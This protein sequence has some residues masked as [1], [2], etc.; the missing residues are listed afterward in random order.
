MQHPS[1]IQI[2]CIASYIEACGELE[3][4]PFFGKD[5]QL[6]TK[7]ATSAKVWFLGDRFHF[8][9]ALISF[10]R[11]WMPTE[12]SSWVEVA[13]LLT[14]P[15]LPAAFAKMARHEVAQIRAGIA[16]SLYPTK[17]T[18]ERTI[19]LWLNTVFAHGGIAGP[20]KPKV[21]NHRKDFEAAVDKHGHAAFEFACRQAVRMIGTHFLNLARLSARP[22]LAHYEITN[23]LKPSFRIG[24]A[25]GAK[26]RERMANGHIIIRQASSEFFHEEGIA[27]RFIRILDRPEHRNIKYVLNSLE[28]APAELLRVVLLRNSLTDVLTEME[29]E[30]RLALTG[31]DLMNCSR[32]RSSSGIGTSRVNVYDNNIVETDSVGAPVL[33]AAYGAFRNQLLREKSCSL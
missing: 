30:M 19:E 29:G 21:K 25:F 28:A 31:E 13:P 17:M 27:E 9:S 26:L 2:D 23:G 20:K 1:Q 12:P 7:S 11:L 32:L 3:R 14:Q 24:A 15:G 8:R 33:D 22:V 6:G 5:E 18:A 10:R 16:Q 4:E